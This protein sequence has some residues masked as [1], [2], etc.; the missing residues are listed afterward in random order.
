M[1]IAMNTP[2]VLAGFP[3]LLASTQLV[4]S[5]SASYSQTTDGDTPAHIARTVASTL[6]VDYLFTELQQ[7]TTFTD[8]RMRPYE[9]A[10]VRW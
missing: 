4:Q 10:T 2:G 5:S 3:Y 8:I 1:S 7:N 9:R 6:N